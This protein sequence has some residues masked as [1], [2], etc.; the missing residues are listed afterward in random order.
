MGKTFKHNQDFG[1]ARKRKFE[2]RRK[3]K[4]RKIVAHE[5]NLEPKNEETSPKQE[6]QKN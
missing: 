4:L 1:D 2:E 5:R 6:N 3:K